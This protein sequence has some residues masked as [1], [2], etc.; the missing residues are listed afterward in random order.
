MFTI[1][2]IMKKELVKVYDKKLNPFPDYIDRKLLPIKGYYFHLVNVWIIDG[3]NKKILIQKRS[4]KKSLFPGLY[5][6]V[7]GGV[8]LDESIIM[9]AIREVKEEL[10]IDINS[11]ELDKIYF[12][13]DHKICY[14]MTTYFVKINNL[15]INKIIF[16]KEEIETIK[17]V[18]YKVLKQ[19]LKANMFTYD[20]KKRFKHL[21]SFFKKYLK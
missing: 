16:N 3:I 4:N 13:V 12:N 5:E 14:F 20:I 7:A 15:D 18:D 10:N 6:C 17:F 1:F 2:N 19:M 9:A 21:K 11:Y 8:S